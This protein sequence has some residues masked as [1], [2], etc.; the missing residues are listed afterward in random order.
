MRRTTDGIAMATGLV[1]PDLAR[2][3]VHPERVVRLLEPLVTVDRRARLREVIAM[4]LASV[5]YS[6]DRTTRTT[7]RPFCVHARHS[8]FNAFMCSS[9]KGPRSR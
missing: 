9:G 3:E 8:A 6:I 5:A 2:L 7:A 4:R 1:D